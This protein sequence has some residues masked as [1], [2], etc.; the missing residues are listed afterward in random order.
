MTTALSTEVTPKPTASAELRPGFHSVQAVNLLTQLSAV[1]ASSH[2]V[3]TLYRANKS[4]CMIA[5]SMAS[6]MGMDPLT[7]MQNLYIVN[8]KPSWS[9]QFLIA[10]WNTCGRFSPIRYEWSADRKSCRAWSIDLK[11]EE[12]LVGTTI[13]MAMAKAEGWLTKPGSKWQTMPEQMLMY[14][15][16]AFLCRAFAAEISLGIMTSEE[17]EDIGGSTATSATDPVKID[18]KDALPATAIVVEPDPEPEAAVAPPSPAETTSAETDPVAAAPAE[19]PRATTSGSGAVSPDTELPA[20]TEAVQVEGPISNETFETL[21][22]LIREINPPKEKWVAA[23]QDKFG[24]HV[25]SA[26]NLTESQGQQ[27]LAWARRKVDAVRLDRW[28]TGAVQS[29]SQNPIQTAGKGAQSE[30]APFRA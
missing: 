15:A 23:L 18:L 3:P 10:C 1:F 9:S 12:K 25:T 26:R 29:P 16:A 5:I 22:T 19:P 20:P 2:L 4:N 7:V 27:M 14:R 6:R 8:G 24:S 21:V 11:T 13:T 30:A 28:A 17:S